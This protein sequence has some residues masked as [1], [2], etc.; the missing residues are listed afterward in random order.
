MS[1]TDAANSRE[2]DLDVRVALLEQ[3][4]K[5]AEERSAAHFDALSSLTALVTQAKEVLKGLDGHVADLRNQ[6]RE[7]DKEALPHRVAEVEEDLE[8]LQAILS[9][10]E[11]TLA[12]ISTTLSTAPTRAEL[13]EHVETKVRGHEDA[14]HGPGS[15]GSTRRELVTAG[16][17]GAG[18]GAA[19]I[20]L[21][22]YL[23]GLLG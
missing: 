21:V 16:G 14:H 6:Q 17:A 13:Q 5:Q 3:S 19:L 12:S 7:T 4:H 23:I 9:D 10:A 15:G 11:K 1:G 22:D 2:R 8:G 20:K 18:A